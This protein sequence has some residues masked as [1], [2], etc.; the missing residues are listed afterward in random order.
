MHWV[1]I[2]V[3]DKRGNYFCAWFVVLGCG[4]RGVLTAF[5]GG[6][7]HAEGGGWSG[8]RGRDC[9]LQTVDF[10]VR[11]VLTALVAE[12]WLGVGGA[13]GGGLGEGG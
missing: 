12:T 1:F 2:R 5:D 13:D 7:S 11:G 4:V 8:W 10:G 3:C 9:R 6:S